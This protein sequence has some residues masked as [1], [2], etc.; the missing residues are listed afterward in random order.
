MVDDSSGNVQAHIPQQSA[1]VGGCSNKSY[2]CESFKLSDASSHLG[3]SLASYVADRA[4]VGDVLLPLPGRKATM[5]IKIINEASQRSKDLVVDIKPSLN[6]YEAVYDNQVVKEAHVRKWGPQIVQQVKSK[7]SEIHCAVW[8]DVVG[9]PCHVFSLEELKRTSTKQLYEL[10]PESDL[11]KLVLQCLDKE[12][13]QRRQRAKVTEEAKIEENPQPDFVEMGEESVATLNRVPVEVSSVSICPFS[14]A[15]IDSRRLE[16]FREH[17]AAKQREE[18]DSSSES[19]E[20][21]LILQP[22]PRKSG[23]ADQGTD[24]VSQI[25]FA[26]LRDGGEGQS[27]SSDFHDSFTATVKSESTFGASFAQDEPDTLDPPSHISLNAINEISLR[28]KDL[29]VPVSDDINL[30]DSVYNSQALKDAHVRKWGAKVVNDV[31][32]GLAEI[33]LATWDENTGSLLDGFTVDELRT[34]STMQLYHIITDSTETVNLRLQCVEKSAASEA[35]STQSNA[36]GD[37]SAV[38]QSEAHMA[39]SYP[40]TAQ[41]DSGKKLD[42]QDYSCEIVTRRKEDSSIPLELSSR[43]GRTI[44]YGPEQASGAI[45]NL[46]SM[47]L[48]LDSST[49]ASPAVAA[50]EKTNLRVRISNRASRRH[51]DV[52]VDISG[53]INLYASVYNNQGVKDA[54]VHRWGSHVVQDVKDKTSEIQVVVW[55]DDA[56]RPWRT[57]SIDELKTTSTRDLYEIVPESS[58]LVKLFLEAVKVKKV[59]SPAFASLRLENGK[60]QFFTSMRHSMSESC[61]KGIGVARKSLRPNH[62]TVSSGSTCSGNSAAS[63]RL[64]SVDGSSLIG[65]R[66]LSHEFWNK[67]ATVS[68]HSNAAGRAR[69]RRKPRRVD[70]DAFL[71]KSQR[72]AERR[73]LSTDDM[74]SNF[75]TKW[76][77]TMNTPKVPKEDSTLASKVQRFLQLSENT[78]KERGLTLETNLEPDLSTNHS[79]HVVGGKWD[80]KI[81]AEDRMKEFMRLCNA[82]KSA[83]QESSEM[84]YEP[85]PEALSLGSRNAKFPVVVQTRPPQDNP[86]LSHVSS[87]TLQDRRSTHPPAFRGAPNATF[88]PV[89]KTSEDS[90]TSGHDGSRAT[91]YSLASRH[92]SLQAV[93]TTNA[94]VSDRINRFLRFSQPD[95]HAAGLTA[96]KKTPIEA[97]ILHSSV[98]NLS[99]KSGIYSSLDSLKEESRYT[100]PVAPKSV[101]GAFSEI[102]KKPT[103]EVRPDIPPIAEIEVIKDDDQS[104]PAITGGISLSPEMV[105][106]VFP[107]HVVLDSDFRILQVGNNLSSLIDGESLVGSIV[108]DIIMVANPIPM[109]GKWDWNILDKM[110]DKTIFLE[111][112]LANSTNSKVKIKGTIIEISSSPR[113]VMLAL[114]PNVKNLSELESM[115]LSMG[116]LPL[117]SCQREAVLLGEHSKSE[118]KLTNHLD[119]LHRDLIN[120]MEKQIED[121]TNELAMANQDLE[122]AN[123]QLAIQSARQLEHFAC[124]SHEIRTPLNCIVGMSSLL[125]DD[126]DEMDPMHAD[127]IRMI[128]T[129]GDLL[130]AVVDDVLDYAKL[131]SGSFEVDIKPTNLQETLASVVHS[132]SQKVQEKNIRLRTHFSATLPL[133]L[134]TDSRRLQQVLFNLLGNAG[135]FSK[136]GSVID[137]SVDLKS[138][139]LK[140]EEG[141]PVKYSPSGQ[142]IRF[143]VKDY[144]KGIDKKDFKTIFEPFSQASKETQNVYGGT[145]LG[146]SITSKLVHRLGGTVGLDSKPGKFTEFTVDLPFCGTPVD[147]A[148]VRRKLEPTTIILVE[149][150]KSYDYSFTDHEIRAEPVPFDDEVIRIFGLVVVRCASMDEVYELVQKANLAILVHESLYDF[151]SSEKLDNLVGPSAY[152]LMT[153]G[154]N[155]AIESTKEWHFKSLLGVFPAALLEAVA[156]NILDMRMQSQPETHVEPP[157]GDGSSF[158]QIHCATSPL[159]V[160]SG[161]GPA[162]PETPAPSNVTSKSNDDV[163]E[164]GLLQKQ[165]ESK[166]EERKPVSKSTVTAAEGVGLL[167][168]TSSQNKQDTVAIAGFDTPD[169]AQGGISS[170][171]PNPGSDPMPP[172]QSSARDP[173]VNALL[174]SRSNLSNLG[175]NQKSKAKGGLFAS[176]SASARI[177]PKSGKLAVGEG[178]DTQKRGLFASLSSNVD[179]GVQLP[180]PKPIDTSPKQTD[181]LFAPLKWAGGGSSSLAGG[182]R[183]GSALTSPV[184]TPKDGWAPLRRQASKLKT[185]PP[186]RNLKVL[187]AEDNVVNQKVLSRV[188]SRAGIDDI[189]IVDN[190]KKAV[191]ICETEKFDCIFMDMQMPIM[192]GMEATKIIV[193]ADPRAFVLF[194]TAHALDE[195]KTQ[196]EAVGA[197]GFFSKPFRTSDIEAVLDGL[198]ANRDTDNKAAPTKT[199]EMNQESNPPPKTDVAATPV[200]SEQKTKPAVPKR[201]LKVLYAEDNQVNQKVLSRILTR[202]GVTDITIVDNG[203]KAVDICQLEKYDC[204]FMDMEMPIMG[205]MEACQKI[206]ANN[207]RACVVFVTAHTLEEFKSAAEDAG[208]TSYITKPFRLNDVEALLDRLDLESHKEAS[209]P[210]SPVADSKPA[211]IDIKSICPNAAAKGKVPAAK[212]NL[213]VLYAEDNV[214]NQKVLSR[215]LNRAGIEDITIVDNGKSAVDMYQAEK[216]DCIFLD[217]QMPVMDGIEACKQIVKH[218][219]D[220][221]VIFVTA[222]ALDEFKAQAVGVGGKSFISKPFRLGDIQ[223]VL[224]ELNLR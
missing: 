160:K 159:L 205:G 48:G 162:R 51:K 89:A 110:K 12:Q 195:Y 184:P 187:Y 80:H 61:L 224:D 207:P 53:D 216:Y 77:E 4:A 199:A 72:L 113:V 67:L 26:R 180:L 10:V 54:N 138:E 129:S 32:T 208:A 167:F 120:S 165:D 13:I 164:G 21:L 145:G 88:P 132:I 197:K 41:E 119:Q 50:Q 108:S 156:A 27:T 179:L 121:R 218:D 191:D 3:G 104:T 47:E 188:L 39:V 111:S 44:L 126:A 56:A 149:P 146:L 112:I 5:R 166:V 85:R 131:E 200:C 194:V 192:D 9:K 34:I 203:K 90:D 59:E 76:S 75:N 139:P 154:P 98:S 36:I 8:D 204:I 133:T 135:K 213:K 2:S 150:P 140:K 58:D 157:Q 163:A 97:R 93:H 221:V 66:P 173:K 153:F 86:L 178:G 186:K 24:N 25:H 14:G 17:I 182:S 84:L 62:M 198:S 91:K 103:P 65:N 118:V 125:L 169:G 116:D 130:K 69:P 222:H 16:Q 71:L 81:P 151:A 134:E 42:D 189:T 117:H 29:L 136:V 155:Y 96:G 55:D 37:L 74:G 220:A 49:E 64:G 114:F 23:G 137:L 127:S 147:V 99:L 214:V 210:Q 172:G 206:V 143:S 38:D 193:Q 1:S 82:K 109:F 57:F 201:N 196:A 52:V 100:S 63:E 124:M 83:A 46:L 142:I 31:K 20:E 15:E 60:P 141:Q 170:T 92:M 158:E 40:A 128:N 223:G 68:D 148:D 95:L 152:S 181:G 22:P 209:E 211:P 217:M 176:L 6:L 144:G 94:K 115:E 168:S 30:Y 161:D 7:V 78:F 171:L 107:Y 70:I 123:S 18:D 33:K 43:S 105:K 212:R 175:G 28:S 102:S 183:G 19:T 202:A 45:D 35:M 177:E 73:S 79:S 101:S 219:P 185:P 190:G 215:V 174:S 87:L 11:V 122:R 106:E